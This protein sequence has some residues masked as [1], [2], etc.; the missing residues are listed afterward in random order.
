M[1]WTVLEMSFE[2]ALALSQG[3]FKM[4][5]QD[6]LKNIE[7]LSAWNGLLQADAAAPAAGLGALVQRLK[8][9]I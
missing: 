7:L 9:S 4:L 8:F 6:F 2:L 3:G 5:C 1:D